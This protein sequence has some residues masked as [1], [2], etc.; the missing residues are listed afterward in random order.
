MA[1]S[2]STST[3][4]SWNTRPRRRLEVNSLRTNSRALRVEYCIVCILHNT[5][6]SL[7]CVEC[8]F[9]VSRTVRLYG[10]YYN[11]ASHV[12]HKIWTIA[13]ERISEVSGQSVCVGHVRERCK[14]G[15]TDLDA[16]WGWIGCAQETICIRWGPVSPR[17]MCD[18]S[19]VVCPHWKALGVTAADTQRTAEPIEM[20]FVGWL[21]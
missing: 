8:L 1:G 10:Y 11:A 14:N 6:R 16:A 18:F 12:L 5:V 15:W 3:I 2:Q 20:P 13:T 7:Y 4:E 9:I 17:K 19:G 21:M